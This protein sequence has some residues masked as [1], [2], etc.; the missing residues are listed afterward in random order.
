MAE[1][2]TISETPISLIEMKEKLVEIKK[3]DKELNFRAK[4]VE[5]YLNN[6]VKIKQKKAD[7][8]KA[9]LEALK[10]QRLKQSHIIKIIDI[11]PRDMDSLRAVLTSESTTLK[12]EE[13]S[14]ILDTVKKHV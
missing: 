14:K 13:L 6:T 10:L 9:D 5:E 4:K 8:L 1:L 7:E 3:R 12:Q 2:Q 11:Q